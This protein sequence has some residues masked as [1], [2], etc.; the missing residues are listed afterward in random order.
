MYKMI[1]K[2]KHLRCFPT[3]TNIK[4]GCKKILRKKWKHSNFLDPL[5]LLNEAPAAAGAR[6]SKKLCVAK[7]DQNS[8][9]N[10]AQNRSKIN[11]IATRRRYKKSWRK[12]DQK[13]MQY[14]SPKAP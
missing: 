5:T 7:N 6:F 1:L 11:K 9:K 3:K 8:S 13:N 2:T 14:G 12:H 10:G 4:K